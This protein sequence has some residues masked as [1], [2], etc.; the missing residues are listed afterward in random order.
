[1]LLKVAT[2]RD[3]IFPALQAFYESL[4]LDDMER[5]SIEDRGFFSAGT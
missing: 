4:S 3:T 5:V 2:G 1:M